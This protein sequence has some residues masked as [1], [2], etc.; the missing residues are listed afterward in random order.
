MYF[1]F[2]GQCLHCIQ[3]QFGFHLAQQDFIAK[4]FHLPLADF[5]E[6]KRSFHSF[7][8]GTLISISRTYEEIRNV[9]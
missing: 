5:I 1:C 2:F 4:R 3:T 8:L 7:S 9:L 6:W